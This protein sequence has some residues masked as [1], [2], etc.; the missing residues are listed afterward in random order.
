MTFYQRISAGGI[1]LHAGKILLVRYPHPAGTFLVAPG[2]RMERGESLAQAAEREVFEETGVRCRAQQPVMID[3]LLEHDHQ[4][5]KLWYL[6]DYLSGEAHYT[7]GAQAEGIFSV[8]WYSDADLVGEIVFPEIIQ[9]HTLA[10]LPALAR[11]LLDPG[12]RI[13]R[14]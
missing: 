12:V 14:F 2:G 1:V 5:L 9:T 13:A 10:G 3:N 11:D 6:C 8:G 4:M 7:P